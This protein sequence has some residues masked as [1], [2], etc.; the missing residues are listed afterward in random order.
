MYA[1]GCR[2]RWE[3]G[4][5]RVRLGFLVCCGVGMFLGFGV[6]AD[7]KSELCD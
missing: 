3:R 2:C 4:G 1:Y 7:F 5:L 6:G